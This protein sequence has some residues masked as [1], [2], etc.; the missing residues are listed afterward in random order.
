MGLFGKTKCPICEKEVGA[1]GKSI[2]RYG[3]EYVCSNCYT[4][5]CNT[6]HNGDYKNMKLAE[7]RKLIKDTP[8]INR[9][10]LKAMADQSALV[11][12]GGLSIK[13]VGVYFEVDTA[14]KTWRIP[15]LLGG[16]DMLPYSA[17]LDY[18]LLEDGSSVTKGGAS[19]GRAVVGGAIFG[20]AGLIIGGVTGKRKQKDFCTT[21]QIKITLN[22]TTKPTAYV[23]F[24]TSKTKKTSLLYKMA[25]KNAQEVLSLLNV[26]T[27]GQ[28]GNE[29]MNAGS[30]VLGTAE[31]IKKYKE[32]LDAGAIT[33][34]EFKA[35]KRQLLDL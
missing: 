32:L 21:M 6:K 17:I 14:N 23:K 26:I 4:V 35:K 7:L 19:I 25:C 20:P 9:F 12:Q 34:E 13:R 30:A 28:P 1:L 10:A 3:G 15:G 24:I 31:E 5:I 27:S 22:S 8:R 18:E 33:E 2:A 29:G 11:E 16:T